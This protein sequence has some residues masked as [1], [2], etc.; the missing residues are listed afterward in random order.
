MQE[1][2]VV[3]NFGVTYDTPPEKLQAIPNT[4]KTL[5]EEEELTRFDRS[6]FKGFGDFALNF[7]TVYY[8]AVPDYNVFMDIQQSI[9]LKL[10]RSFDEDGIEF[11]YPTQTI[12]LEKSS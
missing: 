5:V 11:A 4:V 3:F 8:V 7:E 9:N 12:Y 2:R 6:H 10:C 1:R